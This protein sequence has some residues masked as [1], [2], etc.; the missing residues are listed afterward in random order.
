MRAW[1]FFPSF[2]RK[3]KKASRIIFEKKL[4]GTFKKN[5]FFDA[6]ECW[7]WELC[8]PALVTK[9][10]FLAKNL[11][12]FVHFLKTLG[13]GPQGGF[14]GEFFHLPEILLPGFGLDFYGY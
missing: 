4:K 11:G 1:N 3:T 13:Q 6:P 14:L 10:K 2:E 8:Q 7:Q 9:K 5:I 12:F